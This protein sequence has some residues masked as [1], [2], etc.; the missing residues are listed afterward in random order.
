MTSTN[1]IIQVPH[2]V[3]NRS[4]REVIIQPSWQWGNVRV[5]DIVESY[6]T[7]SLYTFKSASDQEYIWCRNIIKARVTNQYILYACCSYHVLALGTYLHYF[8]LKWSA[9]V[10]Q[11][12]VY[13]W[14]DN[15]LIVLWWFIHTKIQLTIK[16]CETL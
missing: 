3:E 4:T 16:T 9:Q 12:N 1:M 15:M 2:L 10:K 11:K 7:K 8:I 14:N 5:G 13:K 6:K